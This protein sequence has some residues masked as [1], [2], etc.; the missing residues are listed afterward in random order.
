[1][2]SAQ[3]RSV[4]RAPWMARPPLHLAGQEVVI[5]RLL[6]THAN[7]TRAQACDALYGGRASGG[8]ENPDGV[9]SVLVARLRRRLVDAGLTRDMIVTLWC[10]GWH[11]APGAREAILALGEGDEL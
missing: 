7:V 11:L 2:E 8:P 9:L 4:T 5:M 10:Q 6:L 3:A 1:M